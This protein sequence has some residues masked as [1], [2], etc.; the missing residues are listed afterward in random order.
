[1][2]PTYLDMLTLIREVTKNISEVMEQKLV[3][4]NTTLES[5]NNKLDIHHGR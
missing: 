1:M 4:L 3:P 5:I 2:D